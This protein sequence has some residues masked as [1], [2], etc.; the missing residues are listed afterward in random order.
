MQYCAYCGD[1]YNQGKHKLR[2]IGLYVYEVLQR[3][4]WHAAHIRGRYE[5]LHGQVVPASTYEVLKQ[6]KKSY[7][8]WAEK[9]AVLIE[10]ASLCLLSIYVKKWFLK[11]LSH[12]RVCTDTDDMGNS[13]SLPTCLSCCSTACWNW[14]R[15]QSRP[16]S[17]LWYLARNGRIS[18]SLAYDV[19][20]RTRKLIDAKLTNPHSLLSLILDRK[21]SHHKLAALKCGW[22]NEAEAVLAYVARQ[23]SSHID[24]KVETCGLFIDQQHRITT[25]VHN[26]L[27]LWKYVTVH[28]YIC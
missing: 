2:S 25:D 28:V 10:D 14:N 21:M 9:I 23:H 6:S 8:R 11:I 17:Q 5:V 22:E 7:F 13:L 18:A 1:H 24:V 20:V 19:L 12:T 4:R 3:Q 26:V 16:D 15:L 27:K